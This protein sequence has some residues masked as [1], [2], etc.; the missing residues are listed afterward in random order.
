MDTG[1]LYIWIFIGG[2]AVLIELATVSFGYIFVGMAAFLAA[3]ICALG[4]PLALQI[5]AFVVSLILS[6]V[7]L[8]PRVVKKISSHTKIPGRME[9]LHGKVGHVTEAI[10]AVEGKGR[11]LV[12]GEDWA[13][14]S[15]VAIA[16]GEI[17]KVTGHDGIKLKVE[18]KEG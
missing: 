15:A 6:F 1:Y 14:E 9:S 5:A 11:I 10:D 13:A 4:F 7:L 3:A 16:A 12:E 17:V 8:R 2:L 18:K